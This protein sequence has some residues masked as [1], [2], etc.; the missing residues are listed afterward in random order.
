MDTHDVVAATNEASFPQAGHQ[1]KITGGCVAGDE[2]SSLS[3]NPGNEIESRTDDLAVE[4]LEGNLRAAGARVDRIKAAQREVHSDV[5][6]LSHEVA[7]RERRLFFLLVVAA[8]G[9]LAAIVA[10]IVV[11]S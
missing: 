1:S 6:Q 9:V 4:K 5:V 11:A 7:S 8:C 10:T 2:P 3:E